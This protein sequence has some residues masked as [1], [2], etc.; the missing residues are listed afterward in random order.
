ML[1]LLFLMAFTV[2]NIE[3]GL[4]LPLWSK[5]AKWFHP[6][7]TTSEFH[8]ALF[9]VTI[10]GYLITF[11]SFL[12]GQASPVVEGVYVGFVAMM[13]LNALF[14]H[15]ISTIVL[16]KYAPGTI[17]AIFLN[18]PIG[19]WILFLYFK[20][21]LPVQYIVGGTIAVIAVVLLLMK[22]LFALGRILIKE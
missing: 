13:V 15:L 5:K 12:F 19:A 3:E 22:P 21:G 9:A 18:A 2:H 17:T 1:K 20:G 11:A 8:F 10:I 16:R 7:V 14:P 6:E 4:W